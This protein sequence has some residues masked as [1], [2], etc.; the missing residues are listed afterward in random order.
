[1]YLLDFNEGGHTLATIS[2][3]LEKNIFYLVLKEGGQNL[4]TSSSWYKKKY[5]LV[6]KE[7]GHDRA[8]LSS[9][10]VYILVSYTERGW[11]DHHLLL[12][13]KIVYI[14][15][16]Y[17][18]FVFLAI[19]ATIRRHWESPW[20]PVFWIFRCIYKNKNKHIFGNTW[21]LWASDTF[22]KSLAYRRVTLVWPGEEAPKNIYWQ[23][24]NKVFKK[25]TLIY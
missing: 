4:A 9:S 12:K 16:V 11:H 6:W 14:C 2:S 3:W 18:L 20:S 8:T 5:F 23:Q 17:V 10:F 7:W 15:Y 19:G 22:M 25:I 1:M 24:G 21:K 13:K